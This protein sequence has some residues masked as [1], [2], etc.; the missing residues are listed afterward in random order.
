MTP[1]L[2]LIREKPEDE[3]TMGVLTMK[4][5]VLTQTMEPG[6]ADLEFPRVPAGF[7]VC[8]PHGWEPETQ[9][10]FKKTWA[11][12]G[13]GVVHQAEQFSTW[14]QPVSPGDPRIACLLHGGVRDEHTRGCILQGLSRGITMGEKSLLR[15]P[16]AM[17]LL[18]NRIGNRHWYLSI[19]EPKK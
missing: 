17:D 5:Q 12:V 1:W 4:G 13:Q 16:E 15:Y 14:I 2:I 8:E 10:R 11:L 3:R 19:L 18:R 6:F 9:L 7:Y